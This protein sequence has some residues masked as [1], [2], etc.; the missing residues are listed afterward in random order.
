MFPGFYVLRGPMF[1]WPIMGHNCDKTKGPRFLRIYVPQ[2]KEQ[3]QLFFRW[4]SLHMTSVSWEQYQCHS[5]PVKPEACLLL[6]SWFL[7]LVSSINDL[8]LTRRRPTRNLTFLWDIYW[9]LRPHYGAAGS[10]RRPE[11]EGGETIEDFQSFKSH[12]ERNTNKALNLAHI[13]AH[14]KPIIYKI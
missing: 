2:V 1:L 7:C 11:E 4:F 3:Y 8:G 12:T 10:H 9:R 6:M 13:V 14:D 5:I